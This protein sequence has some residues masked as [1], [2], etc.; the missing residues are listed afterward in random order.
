MVEIK[1]DVEKVAADVRA[2][3]GQVDAA[4][5]RAL[6]AVNRQT[7]WIERHPKMA[8]SAIVVLVVVAIT[9]AIKAF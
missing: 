4:T 9:L 6:G 2:A 3:E 7:S 1:Q 5:Q 8:L